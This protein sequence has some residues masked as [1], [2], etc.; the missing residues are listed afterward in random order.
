M[1]RPG[2]GARLFPPSAILLL[3]LILIIISF[4]M[5]RRVPPASIFA[6]CAG[7]FCHP[8]LPCCFSD[9]QWANY[10]ER[11]YRITSPCFFSLAITEPVVVIE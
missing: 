6:F 3:I 5:R 4:E 8:L 2:W 7:P 9:P 1:G 10:P 11:F